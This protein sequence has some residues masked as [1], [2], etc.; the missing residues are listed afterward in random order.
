MPEITHL[1]ELSFCSGGNYKAT[2]KR[3][4]RL[5]IWEI[6]TTEAHTRVI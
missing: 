4:P 5:E 2:A 1:E 3:L 6:E